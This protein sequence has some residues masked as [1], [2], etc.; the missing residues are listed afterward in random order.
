MRIRRAS[1]LLREKGR[2]IDSV[3]LAVG[4]GDL[5]TFERAFKKSSGIAPRAY[6]RSCIV[7]R[8]PANGVA[9]R[10]ID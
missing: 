3:A 6:R 8:A 9:A 2:T 7:E 1:Q 4:Y 10:A 5:T